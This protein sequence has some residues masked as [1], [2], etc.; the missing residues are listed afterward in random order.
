MSGSI[1]LALAVAGALTLA[2]APVSA[3]KDQ[4]LAAGEA[5][6]A[7]MA[8]KDT[9]ALGR[10]VHPEARFY[11]TEEKGDSVVVR[12]RDREHFLNA[13]A[14]AKQDLLE[15]MWNAEVRISGRL[16][17]IWTPYDFH[18]DKQ[19]SHCGIDSFQMLRTSAGWQVLT[20][21]YTVVGDQKRWR[22]HPLGKP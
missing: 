3:Q 6:F 11:A 13:M 12:V 9:A 17:T 20:I 4:V 22:P 1:R 5:L 14:A 18:L 19:W 8:S 21:A 2:A 7:A 10:L 15:R 16:A